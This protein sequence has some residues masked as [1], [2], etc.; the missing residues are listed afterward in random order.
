MKDLTKMEHVNTVPRATVARAGGR[1]RAIHVGGAST[2]GALGVAEVRRD[3]GGTAL[4]LRG[5]T[6]LGSVLGVVDGQVAHLETVGHDC[7]YLGIL[8]HGNTPGVS[9]STWGQILRFFKMTKETG[10]RT[11]S[12]AFTEKSF[13]H[14]P[15]GPSH[16]QALAKI[17]G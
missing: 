1:G 8:E 3:I 17:S 9:N 4:T 15:K 10:M 2:H 7:G 12:L 5:I 13:F 16:K 6:P 11:L 14:K